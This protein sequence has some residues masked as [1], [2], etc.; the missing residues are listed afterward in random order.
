MMEIRIGSRCRARVEEQVTS[1]GLE[2]QFSMPP[3]IESC[4][5][6]ARCHALQS[7][8]RRIPS[9][10]MPYQV[11]AGDV[12][13]GNARQAECGAAPTAVSACTVRCTLR[14]P[15]VRVLVLVTKRDCQG[16]AHGR[17]PDIGQVGEAAGGLRAVADTAARSCADET[18]INA[19]A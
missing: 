10:V 6:V 2:S 9:G 14:R 16:A 1:V 5:I 4:L 15:G 7:K 8:C 13:G 11:Q 3:A 12:F 19:G 18:F 17:M